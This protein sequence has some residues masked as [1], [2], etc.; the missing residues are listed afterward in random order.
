MMMTDREEDRQE[1]RK[2]VKEGWREGGKSRK[3]EIESNV[4]P[5]TSNSP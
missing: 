4:M 3:R 1:W 2:K 5:C